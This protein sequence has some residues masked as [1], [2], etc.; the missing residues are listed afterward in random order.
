MA[1]ATGT[2]VPAN[3]YRVVIPAMTGLLA[4]NTYTL[5]VLARG[6]GGQAISTN[7]QDFFLDGAPRGVGLISFETP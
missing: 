1:L 5:T 6:P 3:C 7:T 4:A 2:G